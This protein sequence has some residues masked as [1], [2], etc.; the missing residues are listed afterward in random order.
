MVRALDLFELPYD[1]PE[2]P[3]HELSQ[4]RE[5]LL[6]E[7]V[8]YLVETPFGQMVNHP[9]VHQLVV[10]PERAAL[11]NLQ[12]CRAREHVNAALTEVDRDPYTWHSFVHWHERPYRFWAFSMIA[13]Q[14]SDKHFWRLLSDV[15]NDSDN[16]WE[17]TAG[18][19]A[20]WNQA[21]PIKHSAMDSFE[22]RAFKRLPEKLTIYRGTCEGHAV[23]GMSWTPNRDYAIWFANRRHLIH[24]KPPVLITARAKKAD[25]HALL[26]DRCWRREIEIV[27]DQFD[28]VASETLTPTLYVATMSPDVLKGWQQMEEVAPPEDL[29]DGIIRK[30]FRINGQ[31][32]R[33]HHDPILIAKYFAG[34]PFESRRQAT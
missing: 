19:R 6:P 28:I 2:S 13:D 20:L 30:A 24:D 7:L 11:L 31:L 27:I 25:I 15:W 33:Q 3:Y 8:E 4:R 29:K 10:D 17:N 9:L 18:W 12:Y 21:R 1:E 34:L 23:D 32:D 16:N 14:L 22:R 26:I 5:R